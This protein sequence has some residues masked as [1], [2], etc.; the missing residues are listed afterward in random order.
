MVDWGVIVPDDGLVRSQTIAFHCGDFVCDLQCMRCHATK[1]NGGGRCSRRVCMGLHVCWQ[2][3][4]IG[5]G[6]YRFVI[7]TSRIPRAGKGVFIQGGRVGDIVF[8]TNE[9]V[10]VMWGEVLTRRQV[11]A[12]YGNGGAPFVI[13]LHQNRF[14]DFACRRSLLSMANAPPAGQAANA[15]FV[16]H[17]RSRRQKWNMWVQ[18]SRPIRSGDELLVDYGDSYDF[19]EQHYTGRRKRRRTRSSD[20]G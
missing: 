9:N 12:R 17:R 7:K 16:K 1:R 8:D 3:R 5:D 10:G 15:V 2:H 18:A 14:L 19:D 6:V 4:K 20:G 13:Q 11:N